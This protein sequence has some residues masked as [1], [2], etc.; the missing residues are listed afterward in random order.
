MGSASPNTPDASSQSAVRKTRC[1]WRPHGG[2][3]HVPAH[4]RDRPV[5]HGRKDAV[6]IVEDG[7]VGCLRG[8]DHAKLLDRPLRRGMLGDIQWRIRRVPTSRTTKTERTRKRAVTVVKKSQATTC[9]WRIDKSGAFRGLGQAGGEFIVIYQGHSNERV[10]PH[11]A[12]PEAVAGIPRR[13]LEDGTHGRPVATVR[14]ANRR[15]NTVCSRRRLA[16]WVSRRG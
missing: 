16:A 7:P 1:L 13:L 9:A 15:P 10:G 3:Q 8:N 12:G 4:R 5:D 6:P 11:S 2:L 14:V